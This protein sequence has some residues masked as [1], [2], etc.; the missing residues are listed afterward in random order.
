MFKTCHICHA[1]K[2]CDQ[3]KEAW[4]SVLLIENPVVFNLK[5]FRLDLLFE[6]SNFSVNVHLFRI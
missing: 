5:N 2:Y 4:N 6:I 1:E 3:K